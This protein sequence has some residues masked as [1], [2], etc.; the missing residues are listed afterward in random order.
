[1]F[2]LAVGAENARLGA[3]LIRC[4]LAFQPLRP[5]VPRHIRAFLFA[6]RAATLR[7]AV[8]AGVAARRAAP[9][10]LAV[11]AAFARHAVVFRIAVSAWVALRAVALHKAVR[12]PLDSPITP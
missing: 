4:R 11:G 12:A 9:R 5:R 6:R 7:L 10:Q 2:R 1:V 3:D 8:R